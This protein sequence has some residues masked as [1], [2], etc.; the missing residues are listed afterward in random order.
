LKRSPLRK[1]VDFVYRLNLEVTKKLVAFQNR[2]YA[3]VPLLSFDHPKRFYPK[4]GT[5]TFFV[6]S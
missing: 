4:R 6:A 1:T 2:L 5:S 3:H